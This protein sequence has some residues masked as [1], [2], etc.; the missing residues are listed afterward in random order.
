MVK[1]HSQVSF[2]LSKTMIWLQENGIGIFLA[3]IAF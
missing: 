1:R 3:S 2:C